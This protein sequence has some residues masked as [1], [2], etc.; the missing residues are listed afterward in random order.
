MQLVGEQGV[1]QEGESG[2][3]QMRARYYDSRT[4]RF[5]SRDPVWLDLE[6]PKAIN[7]YQYAGQNPLSFIDPSGLDYAAAAAVWIWAAMW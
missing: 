3:Y 7:P 6:D 4:A 2:L 1:R 5:L